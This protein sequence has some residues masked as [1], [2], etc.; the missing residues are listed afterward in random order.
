MPS[1]QVPFATATA[2][3]GDHQIDAQRQ[4]LQ[5][6]FHT[7]EGR[8]IR[9]IW[10]ILLAES[11]QV[12]DMLIPWKNMLEKM[13]QVILLAKINFPSQVANPEAIMSHHFCFWFLVEISFGNKQPNG[14]S[15]LFFFSW[16]TCLLPSAPTKWPCRQCLSPDCLGVGDLCYGVPPWVFHGKCQLI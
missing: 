13:L 11:S 8:G 9:A 4:S 14:D 3:N 16:M 15:L 10:Q 5:C 6:F 2:K 12:V 7:A 1:W